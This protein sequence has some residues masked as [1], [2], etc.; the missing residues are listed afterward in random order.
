MQ[1]LAHAAPQ[2]PAVIAGVEVS[3]EEDAFLLGVGIDPAQG[4]LPWKG[5]QIEFARK[6]IAHVHAQGGA[7]IALAWRLSPGQV[8]RLAALGIDAIE[9][10]NTGHPDIPDAVR[11][12]MLSAA[13]NQPLVL[14]ASTD[15]H[16][17]SGFTRTWTLIAASEG[18]ARSQ[19]ETAHAVV[20]RLRARDAAAFTPV[21]AGYMGPPG[22]AR[23]LFAPWAEA[24]RYAAEL[25]PARVISWW[26]WAVL[27]GAGAAALERRGVRR[28]AVAGALFSALIGVVLALRAWDLRSF[29]IDGEPH[30][31]ALEMAT[32][33][34]LIALA[35]AGVAALLAWQ[36]WRRFSARQGP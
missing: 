12:R 31:Y 20:D 10:V 2:W 21:A 28:S 14:L 34:L 9:L 18:A 36:E 35:A 16:G 32:P 6:F 25:S 17:W 3:D 26:L 27:V 24:V 29:R 22:M 19:T 23:A 11:E 1:D 8:D 5:N 33:A 15:W 13:R 4:V 30:A 7:V